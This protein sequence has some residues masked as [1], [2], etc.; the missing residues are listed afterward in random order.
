MRFGVG[1]GGVGDCHPPPY[2]LL[3]PP[4]LLP[5]VAHSGYGNLL[6]R[7]CG[8]RVLGGLWALLW[9][10]LELCS[11]SSLMRARGVGDSERSQPGLPACSGV[12]AASQM[13]E[14]L[15]PISYI[16]ENGGIVENRGRSSLHIA[17]SS[18][19]T[20]R[21]KAHEHVCTLGST[22]SAVYFLLLYD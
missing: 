3:Q 9:A 1:C 18:R 15:L 21:H 20:W 17:G 10:L 12:H 11:F 22:S 19:W 2:L 8:P 4:V 6:L 5:M 16:V 7:V 14:V 13:V